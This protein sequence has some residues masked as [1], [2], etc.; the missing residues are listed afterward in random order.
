VINRSV[1]PRVGAG[2]PFLAA[3][4]ETPHACLGGF[5]YVG[6]LVVDEDGEEVEV[7]EQMRCRR[8]AISEHHSRFL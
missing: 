5:V 2:D 1:N 3:G 7:I 6:H 4:D 8:C